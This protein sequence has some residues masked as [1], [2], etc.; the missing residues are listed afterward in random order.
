MP[1]LAVLDLNAKITRFML[2]SATV[3]TRAQWLEAYPEATE[4]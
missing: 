2:T 3:L 4:E 1:D